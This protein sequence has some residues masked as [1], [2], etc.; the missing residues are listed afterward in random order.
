MGGSGSF[1][2]ETY[3]RHRSSSNLE[4]DEAPFDCTGF[5]TTATITS[6]NPEVLNDIAIDDFLFISIG[7]QNELLVKNNSD[8]VA[9]SIVIPEQRDI[10]SCIISGTSYIARVVSIKGGCC[11][12]EIS[13]RSN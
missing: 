8:E 12:V 6:P 7:A 2:Y 9:G 11:V 1:R 5:N 13:P 10:I 4:G 3:G